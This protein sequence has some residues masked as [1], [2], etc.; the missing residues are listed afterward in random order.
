MNKS[1]INKS[2]YASAAI[3][4]RESRG[5][6]RREPRNTR[7]RAKERKRNGKREGE[8]GTSERSQGEGK[9]ARGREGRTVII[10]DDWQRGHRVAGGFNV[11]L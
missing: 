8:A 3:N 6:S 10:D 2:A 1:S 7:G 9:G 11:P 5:I 4:N